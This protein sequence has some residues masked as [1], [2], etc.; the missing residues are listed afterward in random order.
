MNS[1]TWDELLDDFE[2]LLEQVQHSLDLG[3]WE[4]RDFPGLGLVVPAEDPSGPQQTRLR[5]LLTEADD[6]EGQVRVLQGVVRNELE[7]GR[8]ET[9]ASRAYLGT[10]A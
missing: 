1:I 2:D 5:D 10:T 3:T 7:R 9:R 8:L 4:G 6:L